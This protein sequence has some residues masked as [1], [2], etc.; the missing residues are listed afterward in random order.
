MDNN[1]YRPPTARVADFVETVA[2]PPNLTWPK[3]A[4]LFFAV[5]GMASG[6]LLAMAPFYFGTPDGSAGQH[7]GPGVLGFFVVLTHWLNFR[8]L[9]DPYASYSRGKLLTFNI[10]LCAI[11]AL[12]LIGEYTLGENF[13][14][15][16]GMMAAFL[17]L[18]VLPFAA[19]ALYLCLPGAKTVARDGG[20]QASEAARTP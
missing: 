4:A 13:R 17:F 18:G 19:N 5:V 3:R 9:R 10:L 2:P 8:R 11:F 14:Q 12:G 1:A 15:S 7:I 20:N 6:V 16:P